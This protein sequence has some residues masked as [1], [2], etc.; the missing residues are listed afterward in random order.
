MKQYPEIPRST[1]QAFREFKA[2]VFDKADGSNL[3]FEW[4]KKRGWHLQGTRHRLFDESDPIFGPA[5]PIFRRDWADILDRH[6]RDRKY[7]GGVVFLEYAGENSIA[8]RHVL[9]EPHRLILFDVSVH[10]KGFVDP[11]EFLKQYAPL[12]ETPRYLGQLNWTRGFVERVWNGEVE[13]ITFEGVVGKAGE[14]HDIIR[15]KAKTRAWIQKIK[16]SFSAE[17][18]EKIINS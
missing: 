9:E 7:D 8:G 6:F 4:S 13:G 10:R 17:E 18:A 14:R 5:L 16:E 1:G 12:G 2:H 15:A 3:R 11:K